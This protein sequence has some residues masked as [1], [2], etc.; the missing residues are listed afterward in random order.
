[1]S[2]LDVK[3]E[4]DNQGVPINIRTRLLLLTSRARHVGSERYLTLEVQIVP[5]FGVVND[6]Y[7]V[8]FAQRCFGDWRIEA[9][10]AQVSEVGRLYT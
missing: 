8:K 10:G 6:A 3:R 9:S 2:A 7:Q 1:M 5:K 4:L